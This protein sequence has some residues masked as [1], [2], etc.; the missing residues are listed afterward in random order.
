MSCGVAAVA[1]FFSLRLSVLRLWVVALLLLLL[2]V[3]GSWSSV[4]LWGRSL[5]RCAGDAALCFLRCGPGVALLCFLWSFEAALAADT[6][7]AAGATDVR[8]VRCAAAPPCG[9]CVSLR[10]PDEVSGAASVGG[11]CR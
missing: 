7:A 9:C 3:R 2:G 11:C 8:N 6:V 1:G 4:R 10:L 5:C